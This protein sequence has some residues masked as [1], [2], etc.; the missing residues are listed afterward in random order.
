[1]RTIRTSGAFRKQ[2]AL[3]MKRGKAED[4]IREVITLLS[5]DI[6]LPPKNKDHQL[7]GNWVGFRKC[8]I[9][10][11]WL[12][13]YKKHDSEENTHILFLEQT[14]SHSDLF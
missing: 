6:P 2:L 4:K 7:T 8:H 9:Q 13:I 5:Q 11:D 1:M 12:L 3:M 10:P 14:G